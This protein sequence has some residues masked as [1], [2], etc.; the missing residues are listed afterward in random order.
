M[1]E[2][3]D[4]LS[5]DTSVGEIVNENNDLLEAPPNFTMLDEDELL[6][7]PSELRLLDGLLEAPPNLVLRDEDYLF[8]S[9]PDTRLLNDLLEAPPNLRLLDEVHLPV[10]RIELGLLSDENYDDLPPDDPFSRSYPAI[11]DSDDFDCEIYKVSFDDDDDWYCFEDNYY[12][13]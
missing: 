13:K 4:L 9:P 5:I 1:T 3:I 10:A 11:Y 7:A 2:I 12:W 6:E 8:N